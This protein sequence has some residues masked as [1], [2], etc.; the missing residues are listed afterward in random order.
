MNVRQQALAP[1]GPADP[2]TL[3][4]ISTTGSVVLRIATSGTVTVDGPIVTTGNVA[5]SSS[6]TVSGFVRANTTTAAYGRPFIANVDNFPRVVLDPL[7]PIADNQGYNY[8]FDTTNVRT[9]G[10]HTVWR[11]G[12]SNMAYLTSVGGLSAPDIQKNGIALNYSQQGRGAEHPILANGTVYFVGTNFGEVRFDSGAVPVP[13][14]FSGGAAT[15]L[16]YIDTRVMLTMYDAVWANNTKL[17][18]TLRNITQ[19]VNYMIEN[20]Y[21]GPGTYSGTHSYLNVSMPRATI[22]ENSLSYWRLYAQL[23]EF[24]SS[25]SLGITDA[26]IWA[27]RYA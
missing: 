3:F 19:G 16:W 14:P 25:G 4:E 8:I 6:G 7:L 2:F 22:N 11:K 9:Q 13:S 21:I 20:V 27:S 24:P 18:L 10:F 15:G 1:K 5:V 12:G 17:T 23:T 26:Q